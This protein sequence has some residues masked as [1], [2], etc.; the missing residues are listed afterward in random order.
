MQQ[1]DI[2]RSLGILYLTSG[3][4]T[5]DDITQTGSS[6]LTQLNDVTVYF[7][8]LAFRVSGGEVRGTG[9]VNGTMEITNG[10]AISYAA[11]SKLRTE[12]TVPEG[13][14]TVSDK[15]E[16]HF[17][18]FDTKDRTHVDLQS[19]HFGLPD[20]G[21]KGGNAIA[22]VCLRKSDFPSGTR[23][24]LVSYKTNTGRFTDI[25]I[26]C[27]KGRAGKQG[28]RDLEELEQETFEETILACPPEFEYSGTSFAILFSPCV[29]SASQTNLWWILVVCFLGSFLLEERLIDSCHHV[30]INHQSSHIS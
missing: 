20:Q 14:L 1:I 24:P 28:R 21:R 25:K 2:F 10:G 6:A 17:E 13:D 15:G 7:N 19:G 8:E 18:V 11:G 16:M 22:R 9:I 29:G 4:I 27:K 3:D 12:I 23:I 5:F 30:I 26:E